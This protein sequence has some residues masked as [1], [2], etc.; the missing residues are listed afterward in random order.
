MS[1]GIRLHDGNDAGRLRGALGQ[2]VSVTASG[3][4]RTVTSQN[5]VG[6]RGATCRAYIGAHYD[7]VPEGPGAN[8]NASGTATMLEI[9]RVRGTD[10]LCAIAFGSEEVGLRGSQAFVPQHLAGG[11]RFMLNFD[12]TGRIERRIQ[13]QIHG[14][15]LRLRPFFRGDAAAAA[16]FQP[17]DDDVR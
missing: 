14:Q 13:F 10:G 5:V 17:F 1:V 16:E 3:G 7:S 9:A 8:D 11:A 2:S 4:T 6:R 12:M 15:R